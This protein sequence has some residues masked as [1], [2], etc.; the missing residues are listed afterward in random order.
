MDFFKLYYFAK[1]LISDEFSVESRTK[2][3]IY[4]A[5]SYILP[6]LRKEIS[7]CRK[8]RMTVR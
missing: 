6:I 5:A 2:S 4:L 8:R 7:K 1:V 3:K